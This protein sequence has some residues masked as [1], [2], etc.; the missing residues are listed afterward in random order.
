MEKIK[1]SLKL[2]IT[3]VIVSLFSLLLFEM[4]HN[5]II[6]KSYEELY[7]KYIYMEKE[8]DTIQQYI[9]KKEVKTGG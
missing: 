5:I 8:I 9:F 4:Q 1:V 6:Y 3:I 7:D 2:V